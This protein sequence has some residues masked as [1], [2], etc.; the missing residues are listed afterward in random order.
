MS[1]NQ[2]PEKIAPALLTI[3][4]V[5]AYLNIARP[6]FYRIKATGAFGLLPVKLGTLRKVLYSR[7]E[8]DAYLKAGCPHRKIWQTQKKETKL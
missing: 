5:C 2:A 6:T 8:L 1:N 4:Q 3:D 7:I